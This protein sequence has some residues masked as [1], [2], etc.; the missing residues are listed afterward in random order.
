[1]AE[2]LAQRGLGERGGLLAHGREV[3]LPALVAS[4]VS[5]AACSRHGR[6]VTR[7]LPASSAS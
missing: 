4:T 7:A 6:A 3:Q 5:A 2:P 1:M